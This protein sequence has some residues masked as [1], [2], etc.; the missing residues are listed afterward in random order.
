MKEK[1]K[2]ILKAVQISKSYIDNFNI[3]TLY[4]DDIERR[5]GHI[6]ERIKSLAEL[7]NYRNY[8]QGYITQELSNFERFIKEIK[9]DQKNDYKEIKKI[10]ENRIS[11][12]EEDLYEYFEDFLK[13]YDAKIKDLILDSFKIII[14]VPEFSL[15]DA[16]E[17]AS[18]EFTELDLIFN[19][20]KDR[21]TY[22]FFNNDKEAKKYNGYYHPHI[23][24]FGNLCEGEAE[25][26]IERCIKLFDLF[27]LVDIL[28]A[29]VS[30][31]NEEDVYEKLEE[32]AE[33]STTCDC[34][35][36][37]ID[38]DYYTCKYP[39]CNNEICDDCLERIDLDGMDTYVCH[40]HIENGD[41]ESCEECGSYSTELEEVRISG[42]CF[43]SY[44]CPSCK[45]E[46]EEEED[47]LEEEEDE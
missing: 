20:S 29:T 42:N 16:W 31:Y 41:L 32:I 38:D 21:L 34:C 15:V 26:A 4:F 2:D 39:G 22:S 13:E 43:D 18:L 30:T 7:K 3:K 17:E 36:N 33:P 6:S 37:A 25:D 44:L 14:K 47:E 10:K 9:E 5:C 19:V 45:E 23:G 11:Y 24:H 46:L 35:N 28:F 27:E 8:S 12:N 1:D 40:F